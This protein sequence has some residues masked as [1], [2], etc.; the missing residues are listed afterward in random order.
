MAAYIEKGY[1]RKLSADEIAETSRRTWYLPHFGVT[2]SHKPG[3]LRLVF[4]A[5]ASI[6][7]VS[8]NSVL[9]SGPNSN[10]PLAALLHKFRVGDIGVCGDIREM[11][12]QVVIRPEDRCAQRFLW[13]DGDRTAA[14]TVYEMVAMTFGAT[15]SPATA[16][17]VMNRNADEHAADFPQAVR[18]IKELHYVDDYVA[19]FSTAAEAIDV[20]L[21]VTEVHRLGGFELRNF[22]SNN[23]AVLRSIG[24]PVRTDPVDMQPESEHVVDRV[25]GMAWDTKTDM[26]LF[27]PNLARIGSDVVEGRRR[28]SKREVLSAAMSVFD[29]YGMV[30]EFVLY[31]R[32]IVQD[33][34]NVGIGWD[35]PLPDNLYARW[36]KW[37][38][39]LE[40]LHLCR[41]P[42]CYSR[43]ILKSKNIQLHIFAD[44]S[45]RAFAAVAYFRV[46]RA[47]EVDVAFVA[48]RTRC[49]PIKMLSVPR[50]ELQAAVLAVRLRT[51]IMQCHADVDVARTVFWTDSR[52]VVQWVRSDH[53]RYKPFVAHRIAEILS[54][55]TQA[56][57]RW[58][59]TKS[60]VADDATR[61]HNVPDVSEDSRW[62]KG[63]PFLRQEE[64]DW[65][66]DAVTNA[67]SETKEEL[68]SKPYVL[69]VQ[70]NAPV[71]VDFAR[72][73]LYGRVVRAVAYCLR[74]AHNASNRR[75]AMA[76]RTGPIAVRRVQSCRGCRV[77]ARPTQCI[78]SR[79]GRSV[80]GK[81]GMCT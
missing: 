23:E 40:T 74:F 41:V 67:D 14:P 31:A 9:L 38:A 65:P 39:A 56:E 24:A 37:C 7:G 79:D 20:T 17:Y 22:V 80:V 32:L 26:F 15:C 18:P 3:K 77:H 2:N 54:E 76:K 25:L 50:L 66:T 19:S 47:D 72:F 73:S 36:T 62:L 69:I 46:E 28:P 21:A 64:D 61:A 8:L 10:T 12:H 51:A 44:A 42:R 75:L 52:C 63:P 5:A 57:W 4:D 55:S 43:S 16:Q 1:A 27:Q 81:T 48:G 34:C 6:D 70:E 45:E 35:Q 30:A 60:N 53:R 58:V 11:F 29:P 71:T 59:P 68:K 49:A 78:R 13:R 33:L